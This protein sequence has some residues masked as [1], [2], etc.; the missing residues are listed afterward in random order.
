MNQRRAVALFLAVS[1]SW[2]CS[3][4]V[5]TEGLAGSG[6]VGVT[7]AADA[8]SDDGN[9]H[10]AKGANDANDAG[11]APVLSISFQ[12]APPT[13]DLTSLGPRAWAHWGRLASTD[14][15]RRAGTP[16]SNIL[17][18]AS[19]SVQ[20]FD[21]ALTSFRWKDGA[22]TTTEP[23]TTTGVF[24]TGS[25]RP[26][27]TFTINVDPPELTALVFVGGFQST[28]ELTATVGD[29]AIASPASGQDFTAG[30][31]SVVYTV[32]V[33]TTTPVPL[34]ITWAR[35][36]SAGNLDVLAIAVQ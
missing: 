31:E 14:I 27:V 11:D 7:D 29:G 1:T 22:P 16:K 32:K 26:S 19:T 10:D 20:R 5:S 9:A 17:F 12:L 6:S 21:N 35:V 15:D 4:L 34:K 8:G 24:L 30:I 2:G 33:H 36:S 18:S 13:A 28:A 3:L 25:G 23:G